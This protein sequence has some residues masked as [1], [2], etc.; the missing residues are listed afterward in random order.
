MA[1]A[2]NTILDVNAADVL[3]NVLDG[4][5]LTAGWTLEDSMTPSGDYRVKVY[6][7]SAL[8][9]Q[10]G[11]DWFCAVR[12]DSTGTE[13]FFEVITMGAYDSGTKL[14]TQI[15]ASLSGTGT[16][17]GSSSPYNEPV[18]GAHCGSLSMNSATSA[19]TTWTTHGESITRDWFRVIVPSSAF[20]YWASITLDHVWFTTTI[21]PP[22]NYLTTAFCSYTLDV[23]P[24]WSALGFVATN[25]VMMISGGQGCSVSIIGTGTTDNDHRFGTVAGQVDTYGVALPALTSDMLPAYAWRPTPFLSGIDYDALEPAISVGG[26]VRQFIIGEAI[27]IYAVREGSI[28][29]TVEID[30]ATYVLS[31]NYNNVATLPCFAVLVEP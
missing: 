15:A 31:G 13:S 28:G 27:D 8:D 4:L 1:Y 9:N 6:K 2:Q 5:F 30:S 16:A 14:A 7:S 23:D 20:G 12:W 26:G 3:A 24:A 18:T 29:D 17:S 25:P 10:C 11:Y 21:T 22:T 19:T